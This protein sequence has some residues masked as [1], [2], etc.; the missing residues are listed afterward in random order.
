MVI[1]QWD[2]WTELSGKKQSPLIPN[3]WKR[4]Q[5]CGLR[6]GVKETPDGD[7]GLRKVDAGG[8]GEAGEVVL[9]VLEDEVEGGGD[10]GNGEAF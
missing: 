7:L 6:K 8:S 1:E 3:E 2:G 5:L 10:A 4:K 9:H